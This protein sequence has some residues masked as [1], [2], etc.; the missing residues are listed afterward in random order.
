M[1]HSLVG[2][3]RLVELNTNHSADL[4]AI[5]G[6]KVTTRHLS[7]EPRTLDQCSALVRSAIADQTCEPR[8]IYFMMAEVD[9][10]SVGVA[11]LECGTTWPG[12]TT[13]LERTATVGFAVLHKM[14][15]QGIGREILAGLLKLAET[16]GP[17]ASLLWGAVD[18]DNA[19]SE[20]LLT[21]LGFERVDRVEDHVTRRGVRRPSNIFLWG[22]R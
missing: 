10:S 6:S 15:N 5:Y 14:T 16:I 19:L 17:R 1:N 13:P 9:G 2:R 3:I 22:M 20:R 4:H 8:K 7:F 11:R 21:N 18:P 12:G